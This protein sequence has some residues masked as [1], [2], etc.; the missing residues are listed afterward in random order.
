MTTAIV[1]NSAVKP[2]GSTRA[3]WLRFV[4]PLLAISLLI[5][6]IGIVGYRYLSE[7]IR[8]ETQRTLAVIAE[9]K[10]QQIEGALTE[11]RIDAQ[12]YFSTDRKSVV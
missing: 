1:P 5:G 2:A 9:Q 12:L 3:Q 7:E 10:R 11:T 6:V 8:R 4:L